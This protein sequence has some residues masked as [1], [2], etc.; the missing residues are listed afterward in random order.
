MADL[1][2]TQAVPNPVG[3]DRTWTAQNDQLNAEWVEF[4]NTTDKRLNIEDVG[5]FHQTYSSQ[6][7]YTGEDMLTT[8]KGVLDAGHSVRLHTGTGNAHSEGSLHHVFLD[9]QNF[10]WN[11]KCG[12]AAVLRLRGGLIDKAEYDPN[13]PEGLLVRL[14]GTTR[15]VPAGFGLR[16]GTHGRY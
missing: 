13:P 7:G 1:T 14:P 2:V 9:R 10:V 3:K 4:K 11:N 5:I 16:T 12:D 15:L 6:C 8:F